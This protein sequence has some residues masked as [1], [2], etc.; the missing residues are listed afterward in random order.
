[1]G[2]GKIIALMSAG[3]M[4]V[5]LVFSLAGIFDNIRAL[6]GEEIKVTLTVTDKT[7]TVSEEGKTEFVIEGTLPNG[8]QVHFR[9]PQ[10]I[11]EKAVEGQ[12]LVVGGREYKDK[13]IRIDGQFDPSSIKK[14]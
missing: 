2:T 5:A 12:P 4:V 8:K 7:S 3:F 1:M 9:S 10:D 6:E 11:Y 13:P 14:E